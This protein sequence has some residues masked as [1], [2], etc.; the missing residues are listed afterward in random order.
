MKVFSLLLL[1]FFYIMT[2]YAQIS[3][4]RFGKIVVEF[5]KEKKSS[6]ANIKAK[7]KSFV[8]LDSVWV[9]SLEKKFNQSIRIT[10]K[11]K[12]GLYVVSVKFITTKD[13]TI[14][15]I[16]CENDPGFGLCEE[17]LR[18]LKYYG[19]KTHRLKAVTESHLNLC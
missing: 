7:V 18:E 8:G 4:K 15:D 14:S 9:L 2:T 1:A 13:G 16:T 3:N 11:A 17:V 12:K 6:K 19:L 5:T 10:K